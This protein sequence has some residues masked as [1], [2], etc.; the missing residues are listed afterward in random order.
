ML[1]VL[2]LYKTAGITTVNRDAF[3]CDDV[4]QTDWRLHFN[5]D[6]NVLIGQM[7]AEYIETH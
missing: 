3:Y 4:S 5:N 2:D 6:G 1:P 7:I